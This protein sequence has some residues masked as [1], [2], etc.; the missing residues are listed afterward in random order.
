MLTLNHSNSRDTCKDVKVIGLSYER[1]I[2][3]ILEPGAHEADL[4]L[5]CQ[6]DL[7]LGG[8]ALNRDWLHPAHKLPSKPALGMKALQETVVL[9]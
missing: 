5:L 9:F 6:A 4:D 7:L 8:P 3:A 1:F 2:Q